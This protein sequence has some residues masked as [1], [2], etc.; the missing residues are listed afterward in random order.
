MTALMSTLSGV[1]G[2]SEATRV[3]R[4]SL[5]EA[6]SERMTLHSTESLRPERPFAEVVADLS[7]DRGFQQVN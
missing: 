5:V 4:A 6:L 7:S 3:P 1:H 2:E